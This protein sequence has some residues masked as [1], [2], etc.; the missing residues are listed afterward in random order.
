MK[1]EQLSDALNDLDDAIIE[2]TGKL[3]ETHKRRGGTWKRWAAAAACLCVV[4]A[5][6]VV[7]LPRLIRNDPSPTPPGP[8]HIEPELLP[9][10]LPE[11]GGG[12][13][14]E[15]ILLHDISEL[16]LGPWDESMELTR[17]PVYENRSY[18]PAGLPVGLGEYDMLDRL[19]TAAQAL[20]AEILGLEYEWGDGSISEIPAG[21]GPISDQTPE[22]LL[23]VIRVTAR[24]D[25]MEIAIYADGSVWVTFEGG[26]PLPA[27]YRFTDNA[28]D[29]EAEAVLN[30]LSQRFS[31]LLGFSQPRAVLSGDYDFGGTFY[32]SY[33]VYDSG[34]SG[35]EGI[36]NYSFRQAQFFPDDNGKLTDISFSDGL[37][38]ARELGDYPIITADEARTM[39]LNGNYI[40][41]V[42]YKLSGGEYV[43][44][45]ELAYRNSR[46]DE[47]FLP[48][49]RFYVELP[50][51]TRDNGLKTY[52]VYYVPAV[53]E[54]Y[55]ANMPVYDGRF[56]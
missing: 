33:A 40:T 15:G 50:P 27:G 32:R 34:G 3:R 12:F 16:G 18:H 48:Y 38:C 55:I 7:T 56:N 39:L 21:T 41:S 22:D 10:P 30:Y 9:L 52:G 44:G 5:A 19:E 29:E 28:A 25:G 51:E 26:L 49:Y 31:R 24:A 4:L 14:F 13:G 53:W 42:P 54:R 6:A 20:D 8:G 17:L 1:A 35:T 46:T 23:P 45:V 47:Y 43:A 36:L 11:L 2:E 37:A